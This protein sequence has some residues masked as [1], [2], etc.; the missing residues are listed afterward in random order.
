MITVNDTFLKVSK[1]YEH[2]Q[3]AALFYKTNN[4]FILYTLDS[5][6]FNWVPV[7]PHRKW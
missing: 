2:E 4:L 3:L 5:C 1:S 6:L 7:L